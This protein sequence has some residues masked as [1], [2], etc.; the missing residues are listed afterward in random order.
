MELLVKCMLV[1]RARGPPRPRPGWNIRRTCRTPLDS[2]CTRT[3]KVEHRAEG[4]GAGEGRDWA[5]TRT[6]TFNT[7]ERRERAQE[8]ASTRESEHERERA[9]ERASRRESEHE[10][11]RARE[12]ERE[13][14]TDR[15]RRLP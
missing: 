9:G 1:L 11:E 13:R 12:R 5:C 15:E 6:D 3:V 14:Q 4:G 8:R 7:P 10:R 2:S